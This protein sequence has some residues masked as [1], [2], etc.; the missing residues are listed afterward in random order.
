MWTY[1]LDM[2]IDVIAVK[3]NTDLKM[4]NWKGI[5]SLHSEPSALP[6]EYK[7]CKI[8]IVPWLEISFSLVWLCYF[9]LVK[10]KG[11]SHLLDLFEPQESGNIDE[12]SGIAMAPTFFI[13]QPF[14][15]GMW[16]IC[17]IHYLFILIHII[18][19]CSNYNKYLISFF[20]FKGLQMVRWPGRNQVVSRKNITFY[21][22]GAHTVESLMVCSSV[23]LIIIFLKTNCFS[24]LNVSSTN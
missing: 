9:L 16:A 13:P 17:S 8:L 5:V 24:M 12:A 2:S 19:S 18:F 6:A 20:H 1:K 14:I 3:K 15:Q 11:L 23:Y 21:I 10:E 7:K 22:D 4:M